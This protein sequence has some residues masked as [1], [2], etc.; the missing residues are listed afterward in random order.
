MINKMSFDELKQS[1]SQCNDKL[2]MFVIMLANG[3]LMDRCDKDTL[4]KIG[5]GRK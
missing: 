4:G 2:L 1:L 3:E 5:E